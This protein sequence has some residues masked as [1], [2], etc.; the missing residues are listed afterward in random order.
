MAAAGALPAVE[1]VPR[2][3]VAR[4]I[5]RVIEDDDV[6]WIS[7]EFVRNEDGVDLFDITPWNTDPRE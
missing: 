7:I 3:E 5:K 6:K 2:G 4:V 1:D